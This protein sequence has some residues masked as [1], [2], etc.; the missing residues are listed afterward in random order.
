MRLEEES[1][2]LY[3]DSEGKWNQVIAGSHYGVAMSCKS[4]IMHAKKVTERLNSF[5]V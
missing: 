2:F 4:C 5:L 1:S 3:E